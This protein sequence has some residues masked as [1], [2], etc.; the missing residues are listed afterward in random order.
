[1]GIDI[2]FNVATV[3]ISTSLSLARQGLAG[4]LISSLLYLAIAFW[5]AFADVTQTQ[6]AHLGLKK[7]YQAVFWFQLGCAVASLVIF[8]A[9]VRIGEAKGQLTVDERTERERE[10][11]E[12][13]KWEGGEDRREEAEN[14]KEVG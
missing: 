12:A 1:M 5:L 6:T 10:D 11:L 2:T 7:S 9:F 4:A 3:F 14:S 8:L 13:E